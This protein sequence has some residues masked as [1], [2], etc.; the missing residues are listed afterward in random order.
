MHASAIAAITFLY[1]LAMTFALGRK[2]PGYSHVRHTI[3]E[4]GERG[5][6]HERLVAYGLFLPVGL[7]MLLV[8]SLA[9]SAVAALAVCIAAGYIGA[10]LFPCD[11]GSPMWGSMRQHMHNLAGAIQY[12]GGGLALISI[13]HGLGMP[14]RLAGFAVLAVAVALSILPERAGRGAVQWLGELCL[15]GSLFAA[16]PGYA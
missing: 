9:H 4:L 15:F 2:K 11:R 13:S 3:S 1:L 7:A 16:G 10:A 6:P 5:A 8:A 14:F 12:V